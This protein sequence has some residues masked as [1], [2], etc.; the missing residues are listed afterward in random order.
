MNTVDALAALS[1]STHFDWALAPYDIR[2]SKAHARV[3]HGAGLL[4]DDELA[5]M[6]K[7]LDELAAD[8]SGDRYGEGAQTP[9]WV[10]PPLAS[11]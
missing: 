3:L 2:G 8:V 11:A 6:H 10:S 7:A 5:G 1:R 4:T 9:T